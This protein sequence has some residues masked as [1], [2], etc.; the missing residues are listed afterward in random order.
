MTVNFHYN[1]HQG[2]KNNGTVS[3]IMMPT[4]ESN[5]HGICAVFCVVHNLS[6]TT[7]NTNNNCI[8]YDCLQYK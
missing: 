6:C 3:G 5:R 7:T 4:V 2:I 8:I 1:C